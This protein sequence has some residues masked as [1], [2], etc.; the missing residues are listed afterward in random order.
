MTALRVAFVSE[1]ASPL[2]ALGGVDAGGQNVHVAALAAAVARRGA[3][4]VVHTR[5]D[6]P[7]LPERVE[8]APVSIAS[9]VASQVRMLQFQFSKFRLGGSYVETFKDALLRTTRMFLIQFSNS[10]FRTRICNPAARIAP[11]FCKA[12]RPK[13]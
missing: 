11:E 1:H 12:F 3:Q 5:R 9:R 8:M 6:D 10:E 7:S 2:A 13:E 4:V